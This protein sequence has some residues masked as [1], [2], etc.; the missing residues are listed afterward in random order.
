MYTTAAA[1]AARILPQWH[2]RHVDNVERQIVLRARSRIKLVGVLVATAIATALLFIIVVQVNRKEKHLAGI[3]AFAD[4]FFRPVAVMYIDIDNGALVAEKFVIRDRMQRP[5]CDVVED[6]KTT[7][8]AS[9][10]QPVYPCMM[11]GRSDNAK[12]IPVSTYEYTGET[13]NKTRSLCESLKKNGTKTVEDQTCINNAHCRDDA[14]RTSPRRA[15]LPQ[16]P[17]ER[18]AKTP[19]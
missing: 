3:V 19:H 13:G 5:R 12:C 4:N 11:A 6:A 7:R 14:R 16:P 1:P 18:L 9:F 8:F 17:A 10:Q 15:A 2:N